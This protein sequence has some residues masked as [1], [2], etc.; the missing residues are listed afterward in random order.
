MHADLRQPER[1]QELLKEMR[2]RSADNLD[3][4]HWS[5]IENATSPDFDRDSIRGRGDF[6]A[7]L[8]ARAD[9]L[10]ADETAQAGFVANAWS[11]SKAHQL[12]RWLSDPDDAER[13]EILRQ[14]ERKALE[15]TLDCIER[16]TE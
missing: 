5:A 3:R 11:H 10:F 8:V 12:S 1:L 15:L 9:A 13:T 6:A 4:V 16:E 7:E 2:L 14:A